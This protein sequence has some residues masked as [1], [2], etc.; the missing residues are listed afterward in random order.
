MGYESKLLLT[1]MEESKIKGRKT[2]NAKSPFQTIDHLYI[3]MSSVSYSK[4]DAIT[5]KSEYYRNTGII[6]VSYD[7]NYRVV[8]IGSNVYQFFKGTVKLGEKQFAGEDIHDVIGDDNQ[9]RYIMEKKIEKAEVGKMLVN[10]LSELMMERSQIGFNDFFNQYFI[11]QDVDKNPYAHLDN[12]YPIKFIDFNN[13]IALQ[14]ISKDTIDIY[15]VNI[16]DPS[17]IQYTLLSRVTLVFPT[18]L[19]FSDSLKITTVDEAIILYFDTGPYSGNCVIVRHNGLIT[20][21]NTTGRYRSI[22]ML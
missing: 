11:Y 15:K 17:K 3:P 13:V 18:V 19:G 10:A 6:S 20:S 12:M 4:I 9:F 8:N 7:D 16:N 22:T 21:I 1:P 2:W 14:R 5:M